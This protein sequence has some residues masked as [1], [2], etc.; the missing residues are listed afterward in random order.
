MFPFPPVVR[1]FLFSLFE[2]AWL[3]TAL[4]FCLCATVC[5]SC[6]VDRHME[7]KAGELMARMD[8]VPDWRQL[9]RKEISW[10]QALAMMMERNIDLKKSEQSLKTTKR[11]VINVFTQIIPG[12]N[13]DWML[14][15][16][17]SDLAKVTASDVEYNTN[18]LFNMPSLTQIPFDYYSAKAAVYTAEK[19]LE[20][21]KGSWWP[22]CTSRCFPTGM[23]SSATITS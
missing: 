6:S 23:R 7:K 12:V 14:T 3:R 11:S 13:L 22:D 4:C 9:P 5:A 2:R 10:H 20:M 18:I 1:S 21:K 15:K 17:L 19:T 8:A 16:E